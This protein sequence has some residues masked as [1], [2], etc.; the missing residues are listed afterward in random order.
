M[1][2]PIYNE[3]CIEGA[4]NHIDTE[5]VDL[6]VCDPPFGINESSFDKH[7]KR[8]KDNLVIE[9][10]VEAPKEYYSFTYSWMSEAKRI[11][12]PDG[13]F[14]VV[15][16][17]TN[18]KDVL[19][20]GDSL[21]LYLQ[22][23]IVWRYNFGVYTRNKFVTSHYHILYYL[24]DK[25]VKPTFNQYCRFGA[26]EK[27]D[28]GKSLNY[29]DMEDVWVIN[30]EY[31][32]GQKKNKNKLPNA[33]IE[34]MILYSSNE[35]DIVCDFFQG[36]FTT[37]YCAIKLGRKPIGFELNKEAYDYNIPLID[38]LEFG[39]GLKELKE[40]V[41]NKPSNQGKAITSEERDAITQDYIRLVDSGLFKKDI[42]KL[43]CAK[44]KRGKFS[45]INI[46][47]S[48]NRVEIKSEY[49]SS[50]FSDEQKEGDEWDTP[51]H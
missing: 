33:L 18:L 19:N 26:D 38:N 3:D 41:I 24:K 27:D 20:V 39:F 42:I 9:G 28:L 48:H 34:K 35:N 15:S 23:H 31:A 44:Y 6:I 45:I 36:N 46:V 17:W 4:K 51:R 40:V 12:K 7:Y 50:L 11:L 25:K 49:N 43:L 2:Y 10:Y 16:G 5:S 1:T 32:Q 30:K 13:S 29:Q 21:G 47:P 22:N 14:Y 8:K 37:A